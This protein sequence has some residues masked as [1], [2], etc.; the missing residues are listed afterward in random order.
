MGAV[1]RIKGLTK[2]YGD[3][4]GVFDLD[5]EVRAGE[6][7]GYL[8]P[9]SKTIFHGSRESPRKAHCRRCCLRRPAS[10]AT[11]DAAAKRAD[12]SSTSPAATCKR[13]SCSSWCR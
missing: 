6:V 12:A 4:H 9:N 3:G 11:A 13:D 5:L 8:G 2:D 7:F 1:L 10:P